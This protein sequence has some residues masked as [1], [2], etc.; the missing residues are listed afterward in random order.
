MPSEMKLIKKLQNV[1]F[2][3]FLLGVYESLKNSQE[4]FVSQIYWQGKVKK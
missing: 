3:L 2:A 4:R 1:I